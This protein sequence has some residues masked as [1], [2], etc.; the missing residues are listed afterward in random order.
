MFDIQPGDSLVLMADIDRGIAIQ[1]AN[2]LSKIADAI[3]DGQGKEVLP[4]EKEEH[5]RMF[6]DE[7]RKQVKGDGEEQ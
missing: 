5:R 3:F 1:K 2:V 4:N 6:A 7:I